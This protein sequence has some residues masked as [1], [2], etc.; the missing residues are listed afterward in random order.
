MLSPQQKEII[1]ATLAPFHPQRVGVFGSVA[2]NENGPQSDIDILVH[3]ED[4]I[5]LFDLI[6]IEDQLNQALHQKVDLITERSLHAAIRKCIES[7]I[8]YF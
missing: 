5:S 4:R 6:E 3:F 2:R 8:I 7:D 1:K